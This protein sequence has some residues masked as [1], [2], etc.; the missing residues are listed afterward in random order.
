MWSI[1][2]LGA[3]KSNRVGVVA[4]PGLSNQRACKTVNKHKPHIR[5]GLPGTRCSFH[6]MNGSVVAYIKANNNNFLVFRRNADGC[7]LLAATCD[8][9]A[10]ARGAMTALV[11]AQ[12]HVAAK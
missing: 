6:D 2:S 1:S 5:V 10:A 4:I 3:G 9:Y 12:G 11:P 8:S 7:E